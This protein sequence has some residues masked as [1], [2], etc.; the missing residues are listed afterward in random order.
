M[1]AE[2]RIAVVSPGP[3]AHRRQLWLPLAGEFSGDDRPVAPTDLLECRAGRFD[4]LIGSEAVSGA[5]P[6]EVF[7]EAVERQAA[8]KR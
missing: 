6:T 2:N 4:D 8:A 7:V 1:G 5:Q 3:R